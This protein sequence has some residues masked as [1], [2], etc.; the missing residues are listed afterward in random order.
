M[1]NRATSKIVR[2]LVHTNMPIFWVFDILRSYFQEKEGNNFSSA[3]DHPS[4]IDNPAAETWI[5][6]N[7]LVAFSFTLMY[8]NRKFS[9]MT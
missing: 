1:K 7:E 4:S 6:N 3:Y 8:K 2:A 9:I 5:P